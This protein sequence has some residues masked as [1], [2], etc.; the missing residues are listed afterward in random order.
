MNILIPTI[1]RPGISEAMQRYPRFSC[2]GEEH[3]KPSQSLN[4]YSIRCNSAFF[5]GLLWQASSHCR[6]TCVPIP[7][8]SQLAK[9]GTAK[10]FS[11]K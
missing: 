2:I 3:I 4:R 7:E 9:V 5:N 6:H 10:R 8:R 1:S 11:A